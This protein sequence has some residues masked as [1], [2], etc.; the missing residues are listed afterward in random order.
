MDKRSKAA[1]LVGALAVV[2]LAYLYRPHAPTVTLSERAFG[3]SWTPYRFFE[4][5]TP[6]ITLR[7]YPQ[8]VG[9]TVFPLVIANE[10]AGLAM[11]TTLELDSAS[12]AQ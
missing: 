4:H 6:G 11:I 1:L 12:Y 8:Q 7:H 9:A 10:S 5:Q 3:E 2:Y